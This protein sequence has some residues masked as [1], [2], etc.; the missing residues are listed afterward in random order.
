MQVLR[1]TL[2]G[3][4]AAVLFA[5]NAFAGDLTLHPRGFGE[6]TY[7]SWKAKTGEADSRGNDFQS[8]YFQKFVP[9]PTF[10]AAITVIRGLEGTP[11]NDLDGLSWDHREDGHCGA[12][13]PRWHIAYTSGGVDQ[14][15]VLG[16][17]AADHTELAPASGHGWC[18]DE[19]PSSAFGN[20]PSDATITGLFI[21]FDEGP[22]TPN[23]PPV[24]C[25]QEQF[26]GGFVN[27][28]NITVSVDGVEHT[29]TSANDNGNN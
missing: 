23:P 1:L 10:V 20:F 14:S 18:H 19:Q 24:G 21:V 25:N 22:D 9:T 3:L 17:A 7:N 6:Q 26:D 4:L 12:G 15:R 29:W 16:C 27:L 5:P 11:A 28:D 8:L 13:A 2:V